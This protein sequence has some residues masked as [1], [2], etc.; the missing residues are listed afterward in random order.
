MEMWSNCLIAKLSNCQISQFAL[1]T[2]LLIHLPN[3]TNVC[4]MQYGNSDKYS[5]KMDALLYMQALDE[6]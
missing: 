5:P 2:Y 4:K 6:F 3:D 1:K